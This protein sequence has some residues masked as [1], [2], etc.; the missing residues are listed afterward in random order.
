M[1]LERGS[2]LAFSLLLL[3]GSAANRIR[4]LEPAAT[5]RECSWDELSNVL[6]AER[7]AV[8]EYRAPIA[9]RVQS[10]SMVWVGTECRQDGRAGL[11]LLRV[12][13]NP[14]AVIP[15]WNWRVD[16][17]MI[18]VQP[19][20]FYIDHPTSAY[21]SLAFGRSVDDL[22][23]KYPD[24]YRIGIK[25]I[26]TAWMPGFALTDLTDA[27]PSTRCPHDHGKYQCYESAGR[28]FFLR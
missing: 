4:S 8:C 1:N 24:A 23:K 19:G 17:G 20:G 12:T 6:F 9:V 10:D 11:C 26:Q 27:R 15:R 3:A 7:L 28:A 16:D 13:T 21:P 25:N 18:R 22:A 14:D 5:R 2:A